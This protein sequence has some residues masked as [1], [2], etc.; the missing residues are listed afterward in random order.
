MSNAAVQSAG[1]A[2]QRAR[3]PAPGGKRRRRGWPVAVLLAGFLVLFLVATP[4]FL[5]LFIGMLPTFAAMA[6]DRTPGRYALIAVGGTNFAGLV[7]FLFDL[8][9]R[10]HTM[11]GA[12]DLLTNIVAMLIVYS[13]AGFGWVLFNSLPAVFLA[14]RETL[15]TRE[16]ELLQ[17]RQEILLD[18]WGPKIRGRTGPD[19]EDDD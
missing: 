4:T 11:A 2:T 12:R 15:A 7:P 13:A 17:R 6:V 9:S 3:K 10:A 19:S 5:V 14:V 16:S 18:E 8:W 1:S